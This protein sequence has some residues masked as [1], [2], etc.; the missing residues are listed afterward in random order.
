MSCR[1]YFYI[2]IEGTAVNWLPW[3]ITKLPN[4]RFL[5]LPVGF[6]L[7][8]LPHTLNDAIIISV[9]YNPIRKTWNELK[10]EITPSLPFLFLGG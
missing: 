6:R 8:M 7:E 9:E 4:L 1:S 5:L 10:K 2:N 3:S